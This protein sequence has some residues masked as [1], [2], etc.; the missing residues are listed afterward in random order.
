MLEN[1]TAPPSQSLVRK[2]RLG[3]KADLLDYLG[4]EEI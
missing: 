3:N 1:Q 2:L 4:V